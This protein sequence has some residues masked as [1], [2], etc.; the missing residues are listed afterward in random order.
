MPMMSENW[1]QPDEI[2]MEN[3]VGGIKRG[4]EE[5]K[6]VYEH[7][8]NGKAKVYVEFYGFTTVSPYA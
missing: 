4:W 2:V 7:I 8:F 5:I 6:A 3:P 1:A